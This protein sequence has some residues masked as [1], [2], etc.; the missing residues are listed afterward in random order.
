M[1]SNAVNKPMVGGRLLIEVIREEKVKE[2]RKIGFQFFDS[3]F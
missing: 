1:A 2:R 3:A